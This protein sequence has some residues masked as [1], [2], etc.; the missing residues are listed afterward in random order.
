VIPQRKRAVAIERTQNFAER[1]AVL[2]TF[3]GIIIVFSLLEPSIFPTW[4]NFR[5]ILEQTGIVMLIAVGLTIVLASGEFD[6]SFPA[7][8]S[9]ISG[10]IIVALSDWNLSPVLAIL[11]GLA[12]GV[13]IGIVNGSLVATR[14]ASS[15]IL[16][17]AAG[18]VYTGLMYGIAGQAPIIQGVPASYFDISQHKVFGMST[19]VLTAII[20]AIVGGVI[21]RATVFGRQVQAAGS[22][23]EAAAIAGVRVSGVRIGAFVILGLFVAVAAVLDTSQASAFYPSAGQGLF[24]PPF[25]AAFLGTSVLARGQFNVFGTVVGAL[26]I[27]T[28]Q[29]GLIQQNSPSWVI[30]IVQG[31]VLAVA[32]MVAAQRNRRRR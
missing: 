11:I 3:A 25:V 1:Y 24:L 21:L 8:F 9:L 5:T 14:R 16:T 28:L 15:F 17:L 30:N 23:A 7:A 31:L 19:I 20:G 13:G 22:N 12:C 2:L 10:I 32:V 26:F 4:Q 18:S 29:T 27:S 6:L